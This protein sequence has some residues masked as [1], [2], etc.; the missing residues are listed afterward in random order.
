M[1][2]LVLA[3]FLIVFGLNLLIG[4]SLPMWVTGVLAL[5]AGVLL[6]MEHFRARGDKK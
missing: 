1:A 4:L 6:A 5:A 2:H 3:A